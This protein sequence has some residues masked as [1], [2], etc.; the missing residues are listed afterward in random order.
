M[1]KILLTMA[2]L[3][4]MAFACVAQE[5]LTEENKD[6]DTFWNG[7]ELN[8]NSNIQFGEGGAGTFSDGKLNTGVNDSR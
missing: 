5:V 4:T 3:F 2:V 1:K 7:G 6:I 8:E